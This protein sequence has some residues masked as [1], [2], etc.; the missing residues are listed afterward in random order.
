MTAASHWLDEP[1]TTSALENP[2][3]LER[4]L[5]EAVGTFGLVLT[6]GVALC[7]GPSVAALGLGAV[8]MVVIYAGAYRVGA[9]LNPAITLAA[10]LRG[11]VPI[12]EAAA[13]WTTQLAA[14]LGA[15]IATRRT[16]GVGQSAV[17]MML[18]GRV[19]VLA[20]GAELLFT[21]VLAYVIFGCVQSRP[22]SNSLWHLT[23]GATVIAWSV[24][25]AALFSSVYLVSQVIA[26]ACTAIAFLA[27]GS[28]A[29]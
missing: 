19:L 5:V 23:V 1:H 12:G 17:G 13:R 18:S 8:V 4:Y 14:G 27:I 24:D 25:F 15:A 6:V 10:T 20:Y 29:R 3:T 21:F 7:S 22:A 2:R 11:R 9:H 26:G 28:A 16:V